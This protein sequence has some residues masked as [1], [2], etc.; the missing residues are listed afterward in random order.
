MSAL[1]Q[2]INLRLHYQWNLSN[3]IY[4]T[5]LHY[6]IELNLRCLLLHTFPSM[7]HAMELGYM[8]CV[9]WL[10]FIS[11]LLYQLFFY[12]FIHC[13]G[14]GY[15]PSSPRIER[16]ILIKSFGEGIMYRR[17]LVVFNLI[18]K[19][20]KLEFMFLRLYDCDFVPIFLKWKHEVKNF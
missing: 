2:L 10:T 18:L 20:N 4:R 19:F 15:V 1:S 17:L 13:F 9:I 16:H 6:S 3:T 12:M 11:D 5:P 7:N 8:K 14:K